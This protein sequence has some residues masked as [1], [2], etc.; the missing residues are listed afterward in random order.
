MEEIYKNL[1]LEN[2]ENEIWLQVV[3]YEG[4]YEVSNLGRVKSLANEFS[5]KEKILSQ[6]ENKNGYLYVSLCKYGKMKSFRVH[7]L[8]AI[9]FIPNPNGYRCVNHKDENKENNCVDNLEWCTHQYNNT[10]G[11]VVQRRV[12][13]TDYKAI[14]R[15]NAE[16]LTNGVR[17][18]QV[19]QYSLGGILVAIWE[20][21][22][23]CGRQGFNFGAVSQCC[24]NCFNREGNNIYKDFIWSYYPL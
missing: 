24:N 4:L 1:S 15:K 8:V 6:Y 19:Y 22:R 17:S 14:G 5:R 23:E 3:G 20:S 12:A 10:Y 21:I 11:T 18:K 7:R 2:I 16:K 13:H 9:A